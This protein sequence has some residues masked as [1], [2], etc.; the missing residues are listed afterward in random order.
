MFL[1]EDSLIALFT[2]P[3]LASM[4]L[5]SIL[6]ASLPFTAWGLFLFHQ[7]GTSQSCEALG[8]AAW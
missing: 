1:H 7:N 5:N 3:P 8:P 4:V 6:A 2:K